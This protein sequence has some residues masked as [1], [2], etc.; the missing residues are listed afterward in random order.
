VLCRIGEGAVVSQFDELPEPYVQ[1]N[2]MLLACM[3]LLVYSPFAQR[4]LILMGAG[5]LEHEVSATV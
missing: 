5:G 2:D 4:S 1:T 3:T